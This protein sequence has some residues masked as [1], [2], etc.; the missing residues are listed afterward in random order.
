[1][2]TKPHENIHKNNEEV[3]E[4]RLEKIFIEAYITSKGYK[5]KDLK[6]LPPDELRQLM[7]DASI[8]AS[9]KLAEVETRA[10]LIKDIHD[11]SDSVTS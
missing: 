4:S 9:A 8:F 2:Y 3:P 1:M 6:L 5:L 10:R 11:A 7:V